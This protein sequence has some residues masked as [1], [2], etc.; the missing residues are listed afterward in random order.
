ML[1]RSRRSEVFLKAEVRRRPGEH[2]RWVASRKSKTLAN[3]RLSDNPLSD[4]VIHNAHL[5]PHDIEEM[6]LRIDA[7]GQRLGRW[8]LGENWPFS[9][10][11]FDWEQGRD[12]EE[13]RRLLAH[14]LATLEVGRGDEILVDP[15]TQKPFTSG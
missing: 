6:L 1:H 14:L 4:L 7:L 10:R 13:A 2:S 3:D 15:R 8:P 11:E 5:L 9:P 12:I